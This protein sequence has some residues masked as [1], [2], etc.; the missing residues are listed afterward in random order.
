MEEIKVKEVTEFDDIATDKLILWCVSIPIPEDD[1]DE[2]P[3]LLDN[4]AGKDKKKLGPAR[5]LPKVFPGE[6]LEETLH[7]IV[8]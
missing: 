7:I 4:V 3:I 1:N 5:R 2:I 8:K 6:L